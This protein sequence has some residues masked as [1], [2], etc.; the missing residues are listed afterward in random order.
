MRVRQ[1]YVDAER[2][3][4]RDG[5]H[6]YRLRGIRRLRILND[7]LTKQ[8]SMIPGLVF[9]ARYDSVADMGKGALTYLER[10]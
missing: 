7:A 4:M 9:Q 1:I 5:S 6:D 3:E 10:R 2:K 8:S